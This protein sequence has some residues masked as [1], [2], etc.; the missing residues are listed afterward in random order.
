MSIAR[1]IIEFN[2]SNPTASPADIAT[3]LGIKRTTVY[4]ALYYYAKKNGK[5]AAK[6]GRPRKFVTPV[7]EMQK[8]K[9]DTPVEGLMLDKIRSATVGL[10]D[11]QI[12]RMEEEITQ[13]K[14]VIR[15]LEGKVY[16]ASV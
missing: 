7:V 9:H 5:A 12:D 4:S 10:Q 8:I 11:M 14:A 16:G 13:L 6:R 2:K 3:A 1:Q 15:Y